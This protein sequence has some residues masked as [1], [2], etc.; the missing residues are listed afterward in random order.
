VESL[1]WILHAMV[2]G[3]RISNSIGLRMPRALWRRC[4]L[5]KISQVF[6]DGVGEFQAGPP[7][8]PGRQLDLHADQNDSIMALS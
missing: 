8:A 3:W 5:W 2:V 7:A 6:E 1:N 4:R